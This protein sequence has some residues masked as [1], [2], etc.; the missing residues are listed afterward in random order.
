[1][2]K[3]LFLL[4]IT[5]LHACG[6]GPVPQIPSNKMP[7]DHTKENLIEFNK[8]YVELEAEEIKHFIDSL[9]LKMKV[10]PEGFQYNIL[11]PGGQ[12]KPV[13]GEIVDFTYT[14]TMFDGSSCPDLTKKNS[15]VEIGKGKLPVGIEL[16]IS[17]L[18]KGGE[19]DF[20]FP[21]LMAYGVSGRENCIP[22]YTPVRCFIQV[23][24]IEKK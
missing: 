3:L 23:N 16:A 21:A 4:L 13:D 22:P 8:Q 10:A 9:H 2:K 7:P 1:M 5:L 12:K 11:L 6:N 24:N 17:M 15:K 20:I 19:G 14:V 18:G